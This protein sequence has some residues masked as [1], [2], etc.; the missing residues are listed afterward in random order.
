MCVCVCVCVIT[1]IY[2]NRYIHCTCS[3]IHIEEI[4]HFDIFV[5]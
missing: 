4:T 1:L 5:K 2:A 3:Y